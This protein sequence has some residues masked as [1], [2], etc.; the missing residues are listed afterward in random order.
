[1]QLSLLLA[2]YAVDVAHYACPQVIAPTGHDFLRLKILLALFQMLIVS[3]CPSGMVA[4]CVVALSLANT[5]LST[6]LTATVMVTTRSYTLHD[7]GCGNST[8]ITAKR[9]P[10]AGVYIDYGRSHRAHTAPEAASVDK[11]TQA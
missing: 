10:N 2:P 1:M 4:C 11:R 6:T 7:G 8:I 3:A 9:P 5:R